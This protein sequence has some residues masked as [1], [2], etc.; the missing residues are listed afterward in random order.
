MRDF[1]SSFRSRRCA[2]CGQVKRGT[3]P[4]PGT[5]SALGPSSIPW[6]CAEC[7]TA[8]Y[9]AELCEDEDE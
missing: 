3:R 1:L 5:P 9:I 4:P 6:K 7:R 2:T 8:E